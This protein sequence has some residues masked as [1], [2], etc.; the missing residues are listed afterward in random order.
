MAYNK[1]PKDW[2]EKDC[3]D[4]IERLLVEAL[5]RYGK[6]KFDQ[7]SQCFVEIARIIRSVPDVRK[8]QNIKAKLDRRLQREYKKNGIMPEEIA[9]DIIDDSAKNLQRT[10]Q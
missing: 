4:A 6:E 7:S 5:R 10:I 3:N 9:N 2:C 1:V 8:K